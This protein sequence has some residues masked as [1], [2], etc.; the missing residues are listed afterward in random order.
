M[1][2]LG[3]IDST[4]WMVFFAAAFICIAVIFSKVI[5]FF[6]KLAVIIAMLVMV[7]YFLRQAGIL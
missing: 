6:L 4:T 2:T 7:V 1:E 3:S 5:K